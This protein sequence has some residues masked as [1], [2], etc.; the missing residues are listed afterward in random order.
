MFFI[1]R[2]SEL[3]SLDNQYIREDS[4]FVILYGRRRLG[5][6]ALIHQFLNL[7]PN[8]FY[9]MA[10]KEHE[11]FQINKLK[12]IFLPGFDDEYLESIGFDS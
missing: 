3:R 11:Y 12:N 4:S 5:K 9:Y 2:K 8:T 1:N 6:T 10:D 7:Y